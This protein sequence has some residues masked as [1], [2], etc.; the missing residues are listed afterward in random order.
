MA[1]PLGTSSRLCRRVWLR[2]VGNIWTGFYSTRSTWMPGG[3]PDPVT[4]PIVTSLA[5]RRT[6]TSPLSSP[7]FPSLV[8]GGPGGDTSALTAH[9]YQQQDNQLV[10][11][12]STTVTPHVMSQEWGRRPGREG[13]NSV[14]I[15]QV[16]RRGPGAVQ[17]LW[18][19]PPAHVPSDCVMI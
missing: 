5:G 13:L 11:W 6:S 4:H 10:F 8:C 16:G 3:R 14:P 15:L 7:Y 18:R 1:L 9:G 17:A 19:P 12:A 2:D